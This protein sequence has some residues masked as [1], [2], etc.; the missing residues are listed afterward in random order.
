M[1]YLGTVLVAVAAMLAASPAVF[2]IQIP[3]ERNTVISGGKETTSIG[4]VDIEKVFAE[5]PMKKRLQE[6]FQADVEKRK[7]DITDIDKSIGDLEKVIISSTTDVNRAKLELD[8]LRAQV[9]QQPQSPATTG[10]LP[11]TTAS[12][13]QQPS[14]A[15]SSGTV[16]GAPPAVNTAVIQGKEAALKDKE[17]GLTELKKELDKKKDEISLHIKQNKSELAALEEKNTAAVL[18]DI[19]GILQKVAT[20]E[21]VTVIIDKNDVLYGQSTRDLTSKVLERLAG[22]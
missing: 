4:Y 19:Y 14:A 7:K 16:T 12:M 5:H 10:L 13:Q 11:G 22:R 6:E 3:L 8:I 20:D 2:G 17:T 9:A 1:K 18:A 15:A 21:G